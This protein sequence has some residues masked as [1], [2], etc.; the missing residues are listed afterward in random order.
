M[1]KLLLLFIISSTV[2]VFFAQG[3]SFEHGTFDEA[4]KKAKAENKLLF[5]DCYTTWCGPCKMLQNN[6]F[7]NAEVG[8]YFNENF[9][10]FKMDCEKGE[11][12]TICGR[13]GVS[14]YPSLFFIDG[15]G[16][17]VQK[18][19]GYR[20]PESLLA[21]A[22]KAM[23]GSTSLL[24]EY[25]NKYN[26]GE[27]NEDVLRGLVTNLA[28]N[29][30]SF[31][32]Y[33]KEYLALQ[34]SENLLN[35]VNAKMIFELTN[36]TNS[37]S[38][39]YFKDFKSF[40]IDKY[41][42]ESY[43]RKQESIVART[44]K[45]ATQKNDKS[46]F[47]DAINLVKANKM[48]RGDEVITKQSLFFYSGVKDMVNYDKV[49]MTYLKKTKN[50]APN[51]FTE[52]MGNYISNIENPKLLTKAISICR[53]SVNKEDKFYNNIAL[54]SLLYKNKNQAEAFAVAQY[55]LDL[56]KKEGVNYWPAQELINKIQI[57]RGSKK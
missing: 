48:S 27:K 1:K 35:D 25:K 50:L 38:I 8:T 51:I 15:D 30:E 57:E 13:Y 53:K 22:K 34:K 26:S 18:T 23:G 54:A 21:E 7:P 20:P 42:A 56:G 46:L 40:F 9:I 17:V 47:A 32:S 19:M 12:P 24:N 52:I 39:K 11:G 43:E 44:I 36:S 29:G 5:M 37:P 6:T 16:K 4:L 45:E 3:I 33:W 55:A 49:A 41:G 28:K 31:D 2:S 10:S 14:A